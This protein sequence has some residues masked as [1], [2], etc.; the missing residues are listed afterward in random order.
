MEGPLFA[1]WLATPTISLKDFDQGHLPPE[2]DRS[3]DQRFRRARESRER[4]G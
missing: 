4:I 1:P 2:E 3:E